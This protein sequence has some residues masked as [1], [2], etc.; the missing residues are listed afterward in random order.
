MFETFKLT[1]VEQ[2]T[3]RFAKA[4]S[5]LQTSLYWLASRC[6]PT[7]VREAKGKHFANSRVKALRRMDKFSDHKDFMWYILKQQEK[8]KELNDDEIIVNS[9][10][11]MYVLVLPL[12]L[13]QFNMSIPAWLAA[14]QPS[15]SS[16][17]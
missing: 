16:L 4:G 13:N 2:A 12:L 7:A 17:A 10:L 11:F 15:V 3:I 9:A 1:A 14:R 6:M 5:R 8:R